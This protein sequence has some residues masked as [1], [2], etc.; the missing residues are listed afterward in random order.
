MSADTSPRFDIL[1]TWE[2]LN[3]ML[4]GLVDE[5]PDDKMEW[6]PKQELWSFRHIFQH[7][8]EA[9]EQWL[10]RGFADGETDIG[11]YQ[12]AHSKEEIKRAFEDTWRRLE[13]TISNQ[14]N[15]DAVYR[16]KWWA[17]APPRT[18]HWLAFHLLEHDIH[19]RADILL[20]LG[21]LDVET[22]QVWTP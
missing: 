17:E 19:H 7:L 2:N 12:N 20:Y 13:R 16:D 5:V 15:L 3:G 14:G 22:P 21:L 8:C 10:N 18:G 6:S 1:S 9:R 11:I 4:I